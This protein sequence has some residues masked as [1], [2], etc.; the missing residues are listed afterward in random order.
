M[1]IP[2]DPDFLAERA[3]YALRHCCEDCVFYRP[4][5]QPSPGPSERPPETEARHCVHG[6]PNAEHLRAHYDGAPDL[7]V[8]CK[9]F[10]I[11]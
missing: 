10:E 3:Q 1:Y 7:L 5:D 9:E 2:R 4:V 11:P 8:F 6:W